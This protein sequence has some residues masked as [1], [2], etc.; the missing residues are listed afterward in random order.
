MEAARSANRTFGAEVV[1]RLEN[2]FRLEETQ[3]DLD[4]MLE[5]SQHN[6]QRVDEGLKELKTLKAELEAQIEEAK[7]VLGPGSK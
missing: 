7:A 4:Q 1:M 2:S 6:A 3:S 5:M